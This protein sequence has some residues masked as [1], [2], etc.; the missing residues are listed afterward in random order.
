MIRYLEIGAI[1]PRVNRV[2]TL[3][4]FADAFEVFEGAN[5]KGNTVICI[6]EDK[7]IRSRL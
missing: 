7:T 4:D 1:K 2:I 6:S 5:G 3:P